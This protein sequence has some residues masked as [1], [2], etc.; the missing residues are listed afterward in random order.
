MLIHFACKTKLLQRFAGEAEQSAWCVTR[1][2]LPH[3]KSKWLYIDSCIQTGLFCGVKRNKGMQGTSLLEDVEGFRL[4]EVEMYRALR[5]RDC[6][7]ESWS[8]PSLTWDWW[9][10][11][12]YSSFLGLAWAK[13]HGGKRLWKALA[14]P[15][16]ECHS[17]ERVCKRWN[18]GKTAKS[19]TLWKSLR[20]GFGIHGHSQQLEWLSLMPR[21]RLVDHASLWQFV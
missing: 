14:N 21:V 18:W 5:G 11:W 1:V 10:A 17:G 7:D 15:P 6:Q 20:K 16:S 19:R 4:L 13:V 3:L 2:G 8:M 12:E 9:T